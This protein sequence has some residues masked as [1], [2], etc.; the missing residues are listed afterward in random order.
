[1]ATLNKVKVENKHMKLKTSFATIFRQ[2][3]TRKAEIIEFCSSTCR[4]FAVNNCLFKTR[5]YHFPVFGSN[6]DDIV[7]S[8]AQEVCSFRNTI[9]GLNKY[10]ET[11]FIKAT[12]MVQKNNYNN[13]FKT[14]CVF[15]FKICCLSSLFTI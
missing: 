5:W 7:R 6:F 12:Y 8:K 13:L 1:M 10:K 14:M 11:Q 2:T 4:I 9:M 15:L 3:V